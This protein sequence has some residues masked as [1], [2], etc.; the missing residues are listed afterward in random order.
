MRFSVRRPLGPA[1]GKVKEWSIGIAGGQ[2]K[3]EASTVA[4]R[5]ATQRSQASGAFAP[6]H[7]LALLGGSTAYQHSAR[8]S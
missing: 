7:E 1:P 8:G 5:R 3:H 6:T 4:G 2:G